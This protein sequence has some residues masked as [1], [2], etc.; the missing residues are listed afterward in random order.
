M[1]GKKDNKL[2]VMI[3]DELRERLAS[4][5]FAADVTGSEMVRSCILVALP[6]LE[7]TPALVSIM[8]TLP[9]AGNREAN[10]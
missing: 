3:E 6:M 5:A 9:R 2:T 8:P 7:E 1:A 10:R 4:A